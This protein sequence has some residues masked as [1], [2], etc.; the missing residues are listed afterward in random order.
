MLKIGKWIARG[1]GYVFLMLMLIVGFFVFAMIV[2]S[3]LSRAANA[4]GY[5]PWSPEVVFAVEYLDWNDISEARDKN[6][7]LLATIKIVRVDGHCKGFRVNNEQREWKA[8]RSGRYWNMYDDSGTSTRIEITT[9]R[10]NSYGT[11]CTLFTAHPLASPQHYLHG[12]A[13]PKT[14]QVWT[15]KEQ[16]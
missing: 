10:Q 16:P 6:G 11:R 9:E 13:C 4:T 5:F 3:V 15:V 14:K 12:Y 7:V 1:F 2:L 8:C